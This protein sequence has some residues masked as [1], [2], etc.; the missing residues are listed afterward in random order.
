[1]F[2][3]NLTHTHM[4]MLYYFMRSVCHGLPDWRNACVASMKDGKVKVLGIRLHRQVIPDVAS[5]TCS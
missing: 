2:C 3:C 5:L 4:S 1:M